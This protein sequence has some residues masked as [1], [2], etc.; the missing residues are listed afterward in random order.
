MGSQ[1]N[2]SKRKLYL[3]LPYLNEIKILPQTVYFKYKGGEEKI[4][5]TKIHSIMLYR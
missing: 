4:Q 2:N 1:K 5:W 3:W